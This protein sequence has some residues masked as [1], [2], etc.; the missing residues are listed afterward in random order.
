MQKIRECRLQWQSSLEQSISKKIN[1]LTSGP[2]IS[3]EDLLKVISYPKN[4]DDEEEEAKDGL[5]SKKAKKRKNRGKKLV[6][7]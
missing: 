5:L 6:K 4:S 1:V 2:D 3:A 7:D